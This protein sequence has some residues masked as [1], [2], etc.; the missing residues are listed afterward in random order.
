MDEELGSAS[1]REQLIK[2]GITEL[3]KHGISDFSLRR[4][5]AACSISCAAPYKHF[6]DKEALIEGIFDYIENQLDFLL[7]QV[8]EVYSNPK[9]RLV[10]ICI[11][12]VRFCIA[13]PHFRAILMLS[14]RKLPLAERTKELLKLC[15]PDMGK[16]ERES[17]EYVIRSIAYGSALLIESGELEYSDRA[18]ERIRKNL[19]YELG[20]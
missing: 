9:T 18:L 13:N 4:V 14:G 1:V 17:R 7:N 2:A 8:E 20:E 19:L 6:R 10:E 5:A 15:F 3:E 12:Y 11:A 16:T